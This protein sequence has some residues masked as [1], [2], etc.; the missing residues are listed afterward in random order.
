MERHSY[1]RT[2]TLKAEHLFLDLGE[3]AVEL[4]ASEHEQ[5]RHA[6]TLVRESG[7][8]VVLTHL[9]AGATMHEHAAPG[10]M[11]VCVLDGHVRFRLG[12]EQFEAAGGRLVAFDAGIRHVV[13]A[14]EDSTLLLTLSEPLKA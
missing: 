8:S 5:D 13:E 11:T 1:L 3:A 9:R 6:V 10:P 4:R 7:L 12:D 2:H 14:V